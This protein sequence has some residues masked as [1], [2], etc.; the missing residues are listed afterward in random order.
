MPGS[1]PQVAPG[2]MQPPGPGPHQAQPGY[3]YPQHQPHGAPPN[4]P[5]QPQGQPNACSDPN[6][7]S[8]PNGACTNQSC[9]NANP[10]EK[11]IYYGPN[12]EVLPG[13]PQGFNPQ[14]TFNF[15]QFPDDFAIEGVLLFG[16]LAHMSLIEAPRGFPKI[17]DYLIRDLIEKYGHIERTVV[18]IVVRGGQAHVHA[19]PDVPY[20]EP[21]Q[22]EFVPVY[23]DDGEEFDYDKFYSDFERQRYRPGGL[24]YAGFPRRPRRYGSPQPIPRAFPRNRGD[25]ERDEDRR[26]SPDL[27]PDTTDPIANLRWKKDDDRD[28][29]SILTAPVF[30]VEPPTRDRNFR[31]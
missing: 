10:N 23:L 13:P 29:R 2:P 22:H 18:R 25:R 3:G 20:H 28:R 31:R 9:S 21:Y 15:N 7:C 24:G 11:H 16:K 12:G 19:S 6:T 1:Y 26:R 17:P 27:R 8:N 14:G 30:P 4:A 5:G